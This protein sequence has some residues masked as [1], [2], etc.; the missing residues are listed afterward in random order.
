MPKKTPPAAASPKRY[1]LARDPSCHW[2][3]VD[4]SKRVEWMRWA[5]LDEDD[6]ASWNA[7]DYAQ[8][9]E[10]SVSQVEFSDPREL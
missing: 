6:E 9:L 7:P 8:R 5:D 1:F 4:A 10:G 3:L 2:Y